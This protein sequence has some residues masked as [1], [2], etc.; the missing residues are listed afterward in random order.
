MELNNEKLLDI[1]QFI[2][3]F[4]NLDI[5]HLIQLSESV[6]NNKKKTEKKLSEKYKI[7]KF[8]FYDCD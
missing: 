7:F 5:K 2:Y 8:K 6:E 1:N 4:T 3:S